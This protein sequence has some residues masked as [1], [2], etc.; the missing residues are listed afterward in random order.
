MRFKAV[1]SDL[2]NVVARFDNELTFRAIADETGIRADQVKHVIMTTSEPLLTEYELGI[3]DDEMFYDLICARLGVGNHDLKKSE[4]VRAYCSVF[5]LNGAV[6]DCWARCRRAGITLVAVSNICPL[7]HSELLTM[8][9][10][11]LFDRVVVSYR[12]RLRKPSEELMVRALDRA[13]VSAE[14]AI[15]VDDLEEN[16]APAKKLGIVTHHFTDNKRFLRFMNKMGA[17]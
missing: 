17:P 9:A 4:F 7:R 13:G 11:D 15:F 14:E 12:E 5:E 6:L 10:L 2:G 16:L 3:V 1:L 8:G